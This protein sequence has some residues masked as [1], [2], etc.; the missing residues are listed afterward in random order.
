MLKKSKKKVFFSFFFSVVREE[1]SKVSADDRA[2]AAQARRLPEETGRPRR[3]RRPPETFAQGQGT[4]SGDD[5]RLA[6]FLVQ[7]SKTG[8][9]LPKLGKIYH[10]VTNIP[11]DHKITN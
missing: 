9:N 6:R 7:H 8:K 1:E 3:T 4:G 5:G 2:A 11:N 10:M